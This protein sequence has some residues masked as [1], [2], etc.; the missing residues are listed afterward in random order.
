MAVD[1]NIALLTRHKIYSSKF[2]VI[3][4]YFEK[5]DLVEVR[6]NRPKEILLEFAI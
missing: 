1:N 6:V 5:K 2:N 4:Q 3:S